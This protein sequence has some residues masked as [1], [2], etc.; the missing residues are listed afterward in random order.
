MKY[1]LQY[2]YDIFVI[3]ITHSLQYFYDKDYTTERYLRWN[4]TQLQNILSIF[5][6]FVISIIVGGFVISTISK[7]LFSRNVIRLET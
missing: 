3:N 7:I 5:A 2:S 6:H 1:Q 4:F